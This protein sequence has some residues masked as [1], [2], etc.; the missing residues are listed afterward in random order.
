MSTWNNWSHGISSFDIRIKTTP[1]GASSSSR[2]GVLARIRWTLLLRTEEAWLGTTRN[3]G[4]SLNVLT[5]VGAR[6]CLDRLVVLFVLNSYI[7][8]VFTHGSS[9][10]QFSFFLCFFFFCILSFI[11]RY[12]LRGNTAQR[13]WPSTSWNKK[14]IKGKNDNRKLKIKFN[15]V[16]LTITLTLTI[17]NYY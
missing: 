6:F 13:S 9:Q 14:I 5:N 1:L 3:T 7:F 12:R 16:D 17:I 10:S 15:F 8:Q 2:N 11:F 4:F